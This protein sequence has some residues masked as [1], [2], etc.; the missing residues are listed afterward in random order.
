MDDAPATDRATLALVELAAAIAGGLDAAVRRQ[1]GVVLEVGVPAAWVEE[2]VLQSVLMVGWPRTLLAAAAWR[3]I[4]GLPAPS[5]DPGAIPATAGGWEA[6]G[7]VTCRKVYGIN[8]DRLRRNVRALH[9]ALDQWMVSEGYG[10]TLSRPG[11]DLLRRELCTVAQCAVQG[12]IP[13][14]HSHLRGALH[15]GAGAAD[16]R[17]AVEAARPYTSATDRVAVT[18]LLER[19]VS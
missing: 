3:E 4:S 18:D 16:L 6:Q 17:A 12:A 11:L 19:V 9:P 2:L 5:E 8:Y 14:L 7:E 13:Q 1:V 15:A 10:R